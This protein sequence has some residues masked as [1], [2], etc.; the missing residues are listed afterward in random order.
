MAEVKK[1]NWFKR[2]LGSI[3][4]WF[5]GMKSELKKV[6][7]P[8]RSQVVNNSVI[9]IVVSVFFAVII[10]LFDYLAGLGITGLFSLFN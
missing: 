3:S 2:T 7:W 6:V 5:R 4:K 9:V 10:G 1:Q 8:S